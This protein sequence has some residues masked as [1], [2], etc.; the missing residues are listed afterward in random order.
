[1]HI[2]L[3]YQRPIP[4]YTNCCLRSTMSECT[5]VKYPARICEK[6][7]CSL[8][9]LLLKVVKSWCRGSNEW[10]FLKLSNRFPY[11]SEMS[12]KIASCLYDAWWILLQKWIKTIFLSTWGNE[13][14]F[15]YLVQIYKHSY[16]SNMP[17]NEDKAKRKSLSLSAQLQASVNVVS[18]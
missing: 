7:P 4:Y 12:C 6:I 8:Q 3:A 17:S 5:K 1:M 16:I 14:F 15:I 9:F 10:N 11:S 2:R 13:I 18:F